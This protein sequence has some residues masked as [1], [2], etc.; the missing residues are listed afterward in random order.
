M[1]PE[2]LVRLLRNADLLNSEIFC[3]LAEAKVVIEG[4]WHH[5]CTLRPHSSLGYRPLG[6][7]DAALVSRTNLVWH[8]ANCPDPSSTTALELTFQLEHRLGVCQALHPISGPD[9]LQ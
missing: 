4:R 3:T 9:N 2:T 6:A 5:Y 1:P 8:A 7:D